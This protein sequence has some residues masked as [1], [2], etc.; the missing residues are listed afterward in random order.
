MIGKDANCDYK[1]FSNPCTGFVTEWAPGMSARTFEPGYGKPFG[2]GH[3]EV[4][5]RYVSAPDS[6][7]RAS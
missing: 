2:E 4:S 5:I 1:T 6:D 3:Y 7:Q